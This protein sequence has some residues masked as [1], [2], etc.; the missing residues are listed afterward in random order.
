MVTSKNIELSM[1][2]IIN[3]A[4]FRG[5]IFITRITNLGIIDQKI[6]YSPLN[7]SIVTNFIGKILDKC[8]ENAIV[9]M[10]NVVD[11]VNKVIKY[12]D[13]TWAINKVT[14]FDDGQIC[15]NCNSKHI[16][17][18]SIYRK[19]RQ[20]FR[21]MDCKKWWSVPGLVAKK[22]DNDLRY[23]EHQLVQTEERYARMN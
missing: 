14:K 10:Y 9:L 12:S 11:L 13:V 3:V 6:L 5:H 1:K 18:A 15:Q 2:N 23:E 19:N 16:I 8:V 21:C 20:V 4:C 22:S 7:G 17:R